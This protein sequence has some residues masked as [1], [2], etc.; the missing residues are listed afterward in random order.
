MTDTSVQLALYADPILA[1][2]A[3]FPH[4]FKRKMPWVHRGILAILLRRT[5]FLLN[6]GPET[7]PREEAS[8]TEEDL[9]LL[10]KWFVW[11]KPDGTKEPLFF[12][13]YAEGALV[14][15][16]LVLGK[17][18]IIMMPR[19]SAKTTI[20]NFAKIFRTLYRETSFVLL[21]SETGSHAK[22]QLDNITFELTTNERIK[23]VFGELEP[24]RQSKLP[25]T[26][27]EAET[28]TG[29][30]LTARGRG[31]QVRGMNNKGN[32][33]DDVTVDDLED[34]ESVS[35]PEQLD[36]CLNWVLK[37]LL[38][39]TNEIDDGEEDEEG[40]LIE[41]PD[42]SD[43]SATFTFLG[44]ML[45]REMALLKLAQ[46]PQFTFVRFGAKLPDGS[47]LWPRYMNE[48]KWERKKASYAAKGKLSA[49]Y[50]EYGSEARDDDSAQFKQHFL[51]GIVRPINHLE[52]VARAIV[53]DPAISQRIGADRTAIAVVGISSKGQIHLLDSWGKRGALPREQ[54]DQYF[55]MA[56]RWACTRHGVEGI[57]YQAALIHLLREE[58]FRKR[59]YFEIEDI[60]HSTKKAERISGVLQPRYAAG[61][62]THQ[63]EFPTI[64]TMLLDFPNAGFD[65][66]DAFAMAVTLLDPFAALAADPEHDIT[67]DQYEPIEIEVGGAVRHAP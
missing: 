57:A 41:I 49:F 2:R 18:T 29:V 48:R 16:D 40:N 19:G 3:L 9:D 59:Y 52:C 30:Y 65:D 13:R 12:K 14:A 39:V 44:T 55:L 35:T 54:V 56:Q 38:P 63:R 20:N 50:M 28:V 42:L 1:A 62:I 17:N 51:D 15:I 67:E 23:A 43:S 7:W 10:V 58:M 60:R 37:S 47:W 46:D 31:G 66:I 45:H 27:D 24:E 34:E 4:W 5:D 64:N 8:W 11:E 53:I 21:I 26:S 33:P 36:K 6:F 61:Y 32:R 25:W 22:K